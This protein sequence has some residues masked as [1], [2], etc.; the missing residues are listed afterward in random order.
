MSVGGRIVEIRNVS[1]T[2]AAIWVLD[3]DG[4]HVG[5]ETCIHVEIAQD[6]PV[7]GDNIWW[8]SGLVY[9]DNDRRTMNKIGYSHRPQSCAAP[10]STKEGGA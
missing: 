3:T 5:D 9:W 10:P 1:A 7:L 4:V 2:E 8:Q 6:M